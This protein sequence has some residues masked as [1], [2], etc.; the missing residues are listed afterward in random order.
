ML[1]PSPLKLSTISSRSLMK[2]V[3]KFITRISFEGSFS[4]GKIPFSF[5]SKWILSSPK[6]IPIPGKLSTPK[7]FVK[8]EYLPPPPNEPK[9][10]LGW[11]ISNINPV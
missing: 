7:D 8:S 5:I 2:L 3:S 11:L 10:E 1:L 6:D 4:G 9:D